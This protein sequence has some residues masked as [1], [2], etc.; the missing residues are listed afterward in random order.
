[1]PRLTGS[2]AEG[3]VARVRWAVLIPGLGLLGLL[4]LLAAGC[5]TDTDSRATSE[6]P[7]GVQRGNV[8]DDANVKPVSG[9]RLIYGLEADTDGFDPTTNRWAI[10]GVM[11]GLA[12]YDPLAAF[13]DRSEAKPY[14]AKSITP[15][16]DYTEWTITLH[17][18][19]TFQNGAPLTSAAVKAV[20]DAHLASFLTSAAFTAVRYNRDT[21]E[22]GIT[23]KDPLTVVVSMTSPWVAFPAALTAQ[24]GVVPEPG[25]IGRTAHDKPIGTGPFAQSEW[26]VG[27]KWIGKKNANYWRSDQNGTR[28]PYLDE[29]EFRP[30]PQNESRD[31]SLDSDTIQMLQTNQPTSIKKWRD[32]AGKGDFQIVEDNGEGEE[33]L[34]M[35]NNAKAPF[36]DVNVRRALAFATDTQSYNDIIADGILEVAS[37]PFR[38]NSSWHSEPRDYPSFDMVEAQRLVGQ[39]KSTHGGAPPSFVFGYAGDNEKQ[40]QVLEQGW[41]Q[42]GFDVSI[43]S[44]DQSAL[45]AAAIA[46]GYQADLWRQFGAPDPDGEFQWWT[47]T[48]AGFDRPVSD[49]GTAAA[50]GGLTLNIARHGSVCVD[51]ALKRGRESADVSVRKFAYADLQQCFANEVPYVWLNHTVWAV[52]ASNKVRGITNGPLPDGE[53]SLPIGGGGDFG[54]VTRL[55]QAWIAP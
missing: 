34:I 16:R 21:R 17:E 46:G 41:K 12:V 3:R 32:R 44:N 4:G 26:T 10:S 42:A 7:K 1:M 35:L 15:N 27:S 31:A 11:V 43:T 55:T 50:E 25:T 47:S 18:G 37:G 23:V 19:V 5:S 33:S 51:K 29:V 52:V 2:R 6:A 22:S 30:M 49:G 9:N 40:V 48:N 24:T 28:L 36:D 38:A 14:L 8:I 54:G 45:I 20:L 53:P 13:N 39:Y